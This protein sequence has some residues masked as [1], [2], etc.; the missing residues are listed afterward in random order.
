MK[1]IFATDTLSGRDMI[2]LVVRISIAAMMLVHGLPKMVALISGEPVTFPAVLG[3]EPVLSL[4]LAVFAE[5]FCS[6]L[7]LLGL[8]TRAA[9]VPLIVTMLVA[10]FYVHGSDP[11]SIK[12][13]G[14]LYLLI[15]A[16]LFFAGSGKYSVDYMI[17]KRVENR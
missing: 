8:G 16:L 12:E 14:L 17:T 3:M 6:V 2:L 10:A 4:T 7:I 5:V 15:Y 13:I 9:V 1:K 11:F